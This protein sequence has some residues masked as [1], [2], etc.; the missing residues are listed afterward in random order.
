MKQ[1]QYL[2]SLVQGEDGRK[3]AS[4]RVGWENEDDDKKGKLS[5]LSNQMLPSSDP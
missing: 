5:K 2:L 1:S 3:W 4:S